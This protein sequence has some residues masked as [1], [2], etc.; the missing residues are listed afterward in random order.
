MAVPAM[1]HM[2]WG[3]GGFRGG[4]A[5]GTY[6]FGTLTQPV[7]PS[8]IA[9]KGGGKRRAG[10]RYYARQYNP[11]VLLHNT[12]PTKRLPCNTPPRST[13]TPSECSEIQHGFQEAFDF[14]LRVQFEDVSDEDYVEA[15]KGFGELPGVSGF[16]RHLSL[17]TITCEDNYFVL[18]K[19]Y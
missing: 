12:P 19:T 14:W 15:A 9:T 2:H 10:P 5:E 8:G 16:F 6:L 17:H 4:S 18:R 7:V 1:Q 13:P 3:P 11:N